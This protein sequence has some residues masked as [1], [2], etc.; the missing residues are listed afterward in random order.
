VFGKGLNNKNGG[1]ITMVHYIQRECNTD[2]LVSAGAI[3]SFDTPIALSQSGSLTPQ[4]DFQYQDDGSID[5]LRAGSYSVFWYVVNM[6]GQSTVGQ[7]YGLKKFDYSQ[8]MPDWVSVAASSN[9][10]KVAQTPGFAVIDVPQSDIDDYGKATV[11]LFNTS[12]AQANFTFFT[13]KAGIFIFGLGAEE[14]EYTLSN[15]DKQITDITNEVDALQKFV[16]FSEV[17][18]LWSTAPELWGVGVSVISS[19]YTY[20]FWGMGELNL[21]NTLVANVTYYII[22]SSQ[23]EPLQKYVGD[24]TIGTLW[25][26]T[27]E[28]PP[29][30]ICIPVKFDET[31]IYFTPDVNYDLPA[32][33]IFRFTEALI[34]V[35][36]A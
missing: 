21:P 9:H 26:D 11:A 34:L 19:G 35:G 17:I 32:G 3:V 31:G 28:S 27:L 12:D 24:V 8:R 1:K 33:T 22:S 36:G 2:T 6:A 30:T 23:F 18:N 14:L 13:P 10:I 5:I 25:I 4:N 16:H 20:N 7:S 15:I 29:T